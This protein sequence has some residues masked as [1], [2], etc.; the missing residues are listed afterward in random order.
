MSC[1]HKTCP[2][3]TR[4]DPRIQDPC[5]KDPRTKTHGS[6]TQDPGIQDPR[7]QDPRSKT[8]RP[9]IRE[10]RNRDI[11]MRSQRADSNPSSL[12]DFQKK[13]NGLR[14]V[15]NCKNLFHIPTNTLRPIAFNSRQHTNH[16]RGMLRRY[17]SA[18]GNTRGS[19]GQPLWLTFKQTV[20]MI[21]SH[22]NCKPKG[23][24]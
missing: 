15:A 9:E 5:S 6:K 22:T 14:N 2:V 20:T 16:V 17:A 7:I 11:R 24:T 23:K 10:T 13:P 3:I 12:V 19:L 18:C 21:P 4:H 8:I 1:D